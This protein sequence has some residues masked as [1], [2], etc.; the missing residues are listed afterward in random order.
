M[1][2]H[3]RGEKKNASMRL[4]RNTTVLWTASLSAS[5]P[6][7]LFESETDIITDS[8]HG[9]NLAEDGLNFRTHSNS[10]EL[11]PI[12]VICWS[13]SRTSTRIQKFEFRAP[14]CGGPEQI[15]KLGINMIRWNWTTSRKIG[16]HGGVCGCLISPGSH[17]RW[18]APLPSAMIGCY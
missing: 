1:M 7:V 10:S 18:E 17:P 3:N 16:V 4:K 9:P 14:K 2:N 5:G 6:R 11:G 13:L 8:T 15:I 12:L